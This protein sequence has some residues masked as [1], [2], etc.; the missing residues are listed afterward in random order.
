MIVGHVVQV[1]GCDCAAFVQVQGCDCAASLPAHSLVSCV[2][3]C[4]PCTRKHM[5]G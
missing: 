2:L 1:Q 3:G 4:S 5:I